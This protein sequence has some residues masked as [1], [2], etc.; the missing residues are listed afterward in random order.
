MRRGSLD[1]TSPRVHRAARSCSASY[2]FGETSFIFES[3]DRTWLGYLDKRYDAFRSTSSQNTFVLGFESTT[4]WI[5]EGMTSPLAT[6]VE[7]HHIEP[8]PN[9]FLVRKATVSASVDLEARRAMLRGPRAAYPLDNC[10]DT[11]SRR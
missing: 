7:A 6:H 1:L 9:G 11:F 3:S 10:S 2:Q 5:P 4:E 8:R